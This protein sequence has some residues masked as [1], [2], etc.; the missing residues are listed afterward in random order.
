MLLG[1]ALFHALDSLLLSSTGHARQSPRPLSECHFFHRHRRLPARIRTTREVGRVVTRWP[2]LRTLRRSATAQ[3]SNRPAIQTYETPH[4]DYSSS[5][6]YT[7]RIQ[8]RSGILR[9]VRTAPRCS[10]TIHTSP[11]RFR[12]LIGRNEGKEAGIEETFHL[13]PCVVRLRKTTRWHF[14]ES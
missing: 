11:T 14:L 3:R 4:I 1:Y 2:R 12:L 8:I 9:L 13:L 5:H 10:A 7:G 6:S